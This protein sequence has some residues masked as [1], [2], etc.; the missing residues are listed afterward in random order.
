MQHS[1]KNI[2]SLSAKVWEGRQTGH[3]FGIGIII[4]R[5]ELCNTKHIT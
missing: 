2:V 3:Y 4:I 1:L 5:P